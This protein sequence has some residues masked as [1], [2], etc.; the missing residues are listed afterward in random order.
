MMGAEV[1]EV[2]PRFHTDWKNQKCQRNEDFFHGL[3]H[4]RQK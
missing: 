4:F 1:D 3:G 2:T